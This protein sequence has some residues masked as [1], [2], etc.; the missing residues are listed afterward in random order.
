MSKTNGKTKFGMSK[1]QVGDLDTDHNFVHAYVDMCT[2]V[3]IVC[4]C[5][6]VSANCKCMQ[7]QCM[8]LHVHV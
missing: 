6:H 8:W 5:V 2:Y 1:A 4:V 3:C 7:V